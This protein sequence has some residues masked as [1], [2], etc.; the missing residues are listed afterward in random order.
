M[1]RRM[2]VRVAVLLA[3]SCL[4]AGAPRILSAQD[5]VEPVPSCESLVQALGLTPAASMLVS[6]SL[7][8]HGGMVVRWPER[9]AP[10][11]VWIRPPLLVRR[12]GSRTAPEADQVDRAVWTWAVVS[13]LEHWKGLTARVAFAIVR[14]SSS[15]D[16]HVTW[17]ARLPPLP[18]TRPSRT[19]GRSAVERGAS[20]GVIVTARITFAQMDRDFRP[21]SAEDVHTV[22]VHEIGHVLGLAH[23]DEVESVMNTDVRSEQITAADRAALEAWYALPLGQVCHLGR[24]P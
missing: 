2:P 16:V 11:A 14:D 1:I 9:R 20:S 24:T 5:L 12:A 15:A 21:F 22:A 13:A 18:G 6:R 3:A 10:L 19:A 23:H 7:E 8:R 17:V 4:A